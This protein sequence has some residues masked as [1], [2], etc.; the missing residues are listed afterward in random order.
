[1]HTQTHLMIQILT[2]DC[3]ERTKH[4]THG[5]ACSCY[6]GSNLMGR[7][8]QGMRIATGRTPFHVLNCCGTKQT[9]YAL[10]YRTTGMNEKTIIS[11]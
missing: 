4:H 2:A 5:A 3:Y 9:P 7:R 10:S 6:V 11:A 1:M 8:A